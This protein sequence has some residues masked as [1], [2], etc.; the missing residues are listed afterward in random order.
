MLFVLL[1]CF[2]YLKLFMFEAVI[3]LMLQPVTVFEL[4]IQFDHHR[5]CTS[6]SD[7]DLGAFS[8]QVVFGARTLPDLVCSACPP[9]TVPCG[10]VRAVPFRT[11]SRTNVSTGRGRLRRRIVGRHFVG[12]PAAARRKR[13]SNVSQWSADSHKRADALNVGWK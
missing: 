2:L 8:Y 9:R 13:V 6:F 10:E 1:E 7:I 12:L 3:L 5:T 4:S 11:T